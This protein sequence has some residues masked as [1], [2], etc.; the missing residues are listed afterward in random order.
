ML[1]ASVNHIR[2]PTLVAYCCSPFFLD[3]CYIDKCS[4]AG[5]LEE[6]SLYLSLLYRR[7]LF[8]SES[9]A[10][11]TPSLLSHSVELLLIVHIGCNSF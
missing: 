5:M 9:T 10:G 3:K 1:T 8:F 4:L 2:S 7:D 6:E 11:T